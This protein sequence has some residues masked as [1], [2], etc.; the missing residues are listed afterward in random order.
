MADM[1]R[2]ALQIVEMKEAAGDVGSGTAVF[3]TLNVID[4]D[5]DVTLPGAIGEKTVKVLGA[6][7]HGMP[8]IGRARTYEDDGKALCRLR[9]EPE[10]GE[11][12]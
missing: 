12:S 5:G 4:L 6:H 10:A 11:R 1:I 3:A 2:K 7:R 8:W 9:V